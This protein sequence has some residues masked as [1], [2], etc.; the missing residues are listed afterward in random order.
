MPENLSDDYA[1]LREIIGWCGS[2]LSLRGSTIYFVHQSAKDYLLK[3]ASTEV[4]P[5]GKEKVHYI[6]FSKSLRVMS[7]TLRCDIYN[8]GAPGISINQV[9]PQ[10]PD[11]LAVIRY[12]CLYWVD[13]LLDCSTRENTVNDLKDSS[14]IEDFL[15]QSYLYWLEVLSLMKSLSSGIIMIRKLENWLQVSLPVFL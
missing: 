11:P 3:K 12:S 9:Q 1:S 4:F 5:S 6:I 13:H 15:H 10:D 8:L 7:R 14:L 2:L